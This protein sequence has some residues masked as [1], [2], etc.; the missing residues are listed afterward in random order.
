MQSRNSFEKLM[1]KMVH[2]RVRK[3]END[4]GQWDSSPH[5]LAL[6]AIQ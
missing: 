6:S 4:S 3:R 5:N 1:E 2:H